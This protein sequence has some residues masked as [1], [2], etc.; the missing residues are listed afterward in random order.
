M[1]SELAPTFSTSRATPTGC[2]EIF[3]L[4][5]FLSSE[6]FITFSIFSHTPTIRSQ[7]IINCSWLLWKVTVAHAHGSY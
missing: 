7:K 2:L 4:N 1:S 3:L 5:V 6:K